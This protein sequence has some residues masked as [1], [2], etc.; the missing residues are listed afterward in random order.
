MGENQKKTE[1]KA[2][3]KDAYRYDK[4]KTLTIQDGIFKGSVKFSV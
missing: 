4:T 2:F 1:R 3:R